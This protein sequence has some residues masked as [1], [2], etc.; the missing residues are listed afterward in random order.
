MIDSRDGG[1]ENFESLN[2]RY[3]GPKAVCVFLSAI[4]TGIIIV[5]FARFLVRKREIL[6]IRLL[7]YFVTLVALYVQCCFRAPSTPANPFSDDYLYSHSY[8]SDI[9]LYLIGN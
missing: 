2:K 5:L 1:T 7:V 6:A 3:L 9:T 8:R 4:E